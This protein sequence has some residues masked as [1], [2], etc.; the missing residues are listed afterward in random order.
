MR[1]CASPIYLERYGVPARPTD[2]RKHSCIEYRYLAE[3]GWRFRIDGR[4]ETVAATGRIHCNSGWAMRVL[5]LAD[6]GIALL[7]LF[8]I[9]DDL[10]AD[11]LRSIFDEE[12]ENEN[13][14]A[15]MLPPGRRLPAKT[16]VFL[17]F[18]VDRLSKESWW[19]A[20]S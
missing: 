17:D 7:P 3:R 12:L 5:A 2:L 11:R 10:K 15:V 18:V 1:V 19:R 4:S 16:R 14:L 6:Q 13:E 20:L 9:R 8:M